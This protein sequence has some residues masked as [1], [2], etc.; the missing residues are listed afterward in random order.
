[1]NKLFHL[2]LTDI[3]LLSKSKVFYLKLI[4]FP[5]ILILI[6]SAMFG[7]T[8][9]K[10]NPAFPVVFYSEDNVVNGKTE[11]I[12]IGNIFL[13]LLRSQEVQ[14]LFAVTPVSDYA[15][16][17]A[18]I[19]NKKASVFIYIPHNFSQSYVNNSP[20]SINLIADN[21]KQIDKQIVKI[22]VDRFIRNLELM[23]L[24][25]TEITGS[26]IHDSYPVKLT[27]KS[28][29]TVVHPLTIM[30]Y[31][32]IAMTVMFSILTA[33]ELAHG[34]VDDKLNNTQLR[35]KST[36]T[37]NIFYAL[38]KVAGIV[39]AIVVQMSIVMIISHFIF[40]VEFGN[41]INLLLITICYGFA[42]GSIVFC[43]GT[44]ANDHM[45][46][47]SVASF[48]LYG[49]SF[50]GGSFV[51]KDSL[52]ASLQVIQ[53]LIPNG[54]AINCYINVYQGRSLGYIYADLIVL[55]IIGLLFF[56]IGLY[57]Y[58]ERRFIKNADAGNDKKPVKATLL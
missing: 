37:L 51:D 25:K 34:I 18:F 9:N 57:L 2:I 52:P 32:S 10:E 42:I 31:E 44:A 43:A 38:G 45:A 47:S 40:H 20:C 46:I 21:N 55:L 3:K 49:F 4:L 11:Q 17:E 33:F 35:I 58:G 7:N 48:I 19:N 12:C 5:C 27:R 30:Q 41:M 6:I 16:G 1:M 56:S 13:D 8:N 29:N 26:I 53:K 22:I 28:I 14:K 15:E 24:K 54:K 36:P 39:L 23:R 50:L